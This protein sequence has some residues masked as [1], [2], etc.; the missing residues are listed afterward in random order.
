MS[1][2]AE[3]EEARASILIVDDQ[4]LNLDILVNLLEECY[5][6]S[7][8]KSGEGA[9]RAVENELPDL[10]LLDVV[11]P[12]LDGHEVCRRL[13]SD[14]RTQQ[15]PIIFITAKSSVESEAQG[16]E[17]G[18]VDYIAKPFNPSVVKAR[19]A[20]HVRLKL[21]QDR[22]EELNVRDPLTGIANRRRFDSYLDHEWRSAIRSGAP[23][24]LLMMDLDY[25]KPYNDNYGHPEGDECL[26]RV[27]KALVAS[28][29]RSIDLVARYGGE[30]FAAVLPGTSEEG[31]L[32][33]AENMRLAIRNLGIAHGHSPV[34]DCVTLSIGVG[35]TIV[36]RQGQ[37]MGMMER[38]D[39]AL[40]RAKGEGRDCV[41]SCVSEAGD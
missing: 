9:L 40:Y 16:L 13:Q 20:N 21:Y 35:T 25:F 12:G 1:A 32:Q 30:E 14:P 34:A 26:K 7:V 29:D 2:G 41:V 4:K 39:A 38:V 11:M 5:E 24:S 18:A 22:L 36:T 10:I 28:V 33:V 15:V 19:V 6:I 31:A 37:Q 8:A 3:M 23:L 27:A 17:L